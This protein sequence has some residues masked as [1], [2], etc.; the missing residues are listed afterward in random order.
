MTK[1]SPLNDLALQERTRREILQRSETIPP[2]PEVVV[3]ILALLNDSASEPAE[4]EEYLQY[5]HVLVGK[6]LAMAN[7]S[8]LGLRRQV[9][10]IREAVLV[11]GYS[12][13][14]VLV[15]AS[16]ATR[17]LRDD[18][19]CYGHEERGLWRH[20]LVVGV[21]ARTLARLLELS[22][23]DREELFLAGLLHDIGKTV[24]APY[25]QARKVTISQA[26]MSIV[27]TELRTV[28]IDHAEAGALVAA[29]WNLSP[30]VQELL[31]HHHDAIETEGLKL[32]LAVLRTADA[33]AHER[34]AGYLPGRAP[35]VQVL[36]ED[37]YHL[38][39]DDKAWSKA[40]AT[41]DEVVTAAL[42]GLQKVVS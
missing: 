17:M 2:L 37:R 31:K 12:T 15:L 35:A 32:P 25:L 27:E 14:R 26:T 18:Y 36:E 7:S 21:G 3:R 11:L 38:A 20:A 33:L 16:S 42:A 28:G 24:L 19:S 1:P 5:D 22:D 40:R 39:L 8:F 23:G 4:V 29:K 30:T 13:L 10:S 41:L 34:G 9:K 6:V